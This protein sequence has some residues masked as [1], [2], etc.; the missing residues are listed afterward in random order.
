MGECTRGP[1]GG[2]GRTGVIATASQELGGERA[3]KW[4]RETGESLSK[5]GGGGESEERI[6]RERPWFCF[7]GE[8]GHLGR[9]L[10]Y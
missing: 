10:W 1:F 6:R 2:G 5:D 3:E 9:R 8:Q 7:V 4:G